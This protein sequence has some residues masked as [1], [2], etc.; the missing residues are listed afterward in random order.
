[1]VM[2]LARNG[3]SPGNALLKAYYSNAVKKLK[4]QKGEPHPVKYT[5]YSRTILVFTALGKRP[6]RCGRL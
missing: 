5:D 1:M 3:V 6:F 4:T 2:G